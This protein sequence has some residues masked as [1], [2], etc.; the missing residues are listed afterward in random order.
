VS[1][2]LPEIRSARE[3]PR[4]ACA[5]NGLKM[6]QADRQSI[7]GVRAWSLVQSEESADHEGDPA[8]FEPHHDRPR[9]ASP[10]SAH[11]H[12]SAIRA[13]LRQREL[14]PST[15]EYNRCLQALNENYSFEG[16]AVGPVLLD[17]LSHL[18]MDR[19]QATARQKRR[20]VS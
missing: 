8:L 14:H 15:A 7:S 5:L 10:A 19:D 12:E 9:P 20:R 2:D 16:G 18:F 1:I 13:V 17:Q 11:T 6:R 3:Q 4:L